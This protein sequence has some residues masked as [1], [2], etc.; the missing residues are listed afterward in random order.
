MTSPLEKLYDCM[1]TGTLVAMSAAIEQQINKIGLTDDEK[2]IMKKYSYKLFWCTVLE[3]YI[4]NKIA[5]N[6]KEKTFLKRTVIE[7][8]E[9]DLVIKLGKFLNNT[10]KD[11]AKNYMMVSIKEF[12]VTH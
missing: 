4:K 10:T 3:Q 6:F 12:L 2:E 11:E 7:A 9:A 1:A 8:K 5:L